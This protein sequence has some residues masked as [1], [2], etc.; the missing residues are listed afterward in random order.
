VLAFVEWR[1]GGDIPQAKWGQNR[2]VLSSLAIFGLG[3]WD[4]LKPLGAKWK[5]GGQVAV[6][7][8]VYGRGLG[9]QHFGLPFIHRISSAFR[10]SATDRFWLVE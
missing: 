3:F 1:S 4:D 10:R 5:L 9:I 8:L 2:I 6:A 7:V